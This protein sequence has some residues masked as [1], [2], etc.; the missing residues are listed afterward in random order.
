MV[1]L[2]LLLIAM[3][4]SIASDGGPVIPQKDL[5]YITPCYSRNSHDT[6]TLPSADFDTITPQKYSNFSL[7]CHKMCTTESTGLSFI[8]LV[9]AR[10]SQKPT[11]IR[12]LYCKVWITKHMFFL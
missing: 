8:L 12:L 1:L 9:C 4:M 5:W 2:T 6:G 3:N 7:R 11:S 10:E